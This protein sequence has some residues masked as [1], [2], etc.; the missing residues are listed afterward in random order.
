M[1]MRDA[2]VY[3]LLDQ[4]DTSEQV[5]SEIDEGP[6]NA[7]LLV[8]LLFEYEHVVVKELLQ[9]LIGEVNA[10]LLETV[11][12]L[13][14]QY[15]KQVKYGTFNVYVIGCQWDYHRGCK[16]KRCNTHG[17][18]TRAQPRAAN[19][20]CTFSIRSMQA[21]KSIPKSMNSQ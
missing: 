5:H 16:L 4:I 17:E 7:F 8:L 1:T 10:E 15:E 21:N 12:L 19:T 2:I 18:N 9:L 20:R 11:V 3:Y 14:E 6:I 13:Y